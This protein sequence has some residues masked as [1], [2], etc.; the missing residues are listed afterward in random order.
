[1]ADKLAKQAMQALLA[2]GADNAVVKIRE[3][4]AISASCRCGVMESIEASEEKDIAL[5]AL[6][7]KK[8]AFLS[9]SGIEKQDIQALA[10]RVCEMAKAAPQDPYC[11]LAEETLYYQ[12]KDDLELHDTTPPNIE[13]LKTHALEA[14]KTALSE[15]GIK[16]SEGGN[17]YSSESTLTMMTS[18]GFLNT[19]KASLFSAYVCV[20]AE[21]DGNMERDYAWHSSRYWQTLDSPE[22]IGK[23]A[24]KRVLARLGAKKIKSTQA[25]IL[26]DKRVSASL[27]GHFLGAISGASIARGT[28]FLQDKMNE[29]V[30][31]D[32]IT[33]T[34]NPH[35]KRGLGSHLWDGEGVAAQKITLCDKGK[36]K[37]WLLDSAS[38]KKLNL[39]SNGHASHSFG[40]PPSPTA[41]NALMENGTKTKEQI[42]S[43]MGEGLLVTELFGTGVNSVTGDYSCGAA[44]FWIKNGEI[45]QAVHEI[46]I[47]GSLQD[48]F[49]ALTPANDGNHRHRHNTPSLC[50]EGMSIG[51]I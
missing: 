35:K 16:N 7:G 47:A 14:E 31:S 6:F 45:Q 28:S 39:T 50:I 44:G 40:S 23:K 18:Q 38:A 29:Q 4:N 33:I 8:Q 3:A 2:E 51:G 36:L 12:G 43:D 37:N 15:K 48:M 41:S 25:P 11:G 13:E 24:A 17:A 46:T 21:Q 42:M 10:T 27:L 19:R 20:L 49:L 5:H 26:F 34:D 9:A 32:T 30:F 22:T 1:M